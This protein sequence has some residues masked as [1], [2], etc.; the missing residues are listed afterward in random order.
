M[1]NSDDLIMAEESDG[2]G[3]QS[4]LSSDQ[5]EDESPSLLLDDDPVS[6]EQGGLE[7]YS[8]AAPVANRAA[9][10]QPLRADARCALCGIPRAKEASFCTTCGV[11]F[12]RVNRGQPSILARARPGIVRRVMASIIDRMV[13]LPFLAYLFPAWILVVLAYSLFCDGAPTGRSL[14]KRLCRLRV[15]S[16]ASPEPCG[17][18]RSLIRRLGPA[19]CQLAYCSLEL[20]S[21]ALVY[22]LVSLVFVMLNPSGRRMEDYIAGT[23]VI[24]ERVYKRTHRKCVTCHRKVPVDAHYCPDCGT[25]SPKQSQKSRVWSQH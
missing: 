16:L 7:D 1:K 2:L 3:P 24:T 19:L 23:Q 25:L 22:E 9:R 5:R 4:T 14:G 11:A 20:I 18:R 8:L 17:I 6:V 12:A 15:I 10:W 13:P 21:L